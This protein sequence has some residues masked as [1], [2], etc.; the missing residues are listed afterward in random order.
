MDVEK[1]PKQRWGLRCYICQQKWGAC[2]QCGNKTC[3]AA[4]HVTCAR[5][6]RLFLKM[7]SQHGGPERM[8]ASALKAYCDRHVPSD[9][10]RENDVPNALADAKEYFREQFRGMRWGD[11]QNTA[12]TSTSIEHFGVPKDVEEQIGA[13]KRKGEKAPKN[14]WRLPS[15]APVVP[16]IV[17]GKVEGSLV[18]FNIRKRKDYV[19]EASKYWTLKREARRGAALLKRLQ[20]QRDTYSAMDIT[21]RNF[22]AMGAIGRVRLHNRIDFAE[23]LEKDMDRVLEMCNLVLKREQ[24]KADDAHVL[25]KIV[26]TTYFPLSPKL[27]EILEKAQQYVLH[28]LLHSL[29]LMN[30]IGLTLARRMTDRN[31]SRT[32]FEICRRSLKSM[33]T[34]P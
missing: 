5:K 23:L 12:L 16:Q 32:V 21:R 6:S 14:I 1:V 25:Q 24:D 27:W 13:P 26:E 4:F 30:I 28:A 7:K 18:R 33:S 8:D 9:W 29:S 11:A 2:I 10:K 17:Y 34:C 3:F 22:A 31:T 19:A 20:M 15:G